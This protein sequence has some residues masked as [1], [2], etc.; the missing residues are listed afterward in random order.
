MHNILYARTYTPHRRENT[1]HIYVVYSLE[2][3]LELDPIVHHGV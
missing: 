1:R 2:S 3:V